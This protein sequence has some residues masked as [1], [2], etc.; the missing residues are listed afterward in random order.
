MP[1]DVLQGGC[2]LVVG[3]AGRDLWLFGW[4][5]GSGDDG[6]LVDSGGDGLAGSLAW[7]GG[8]GLRLLRGVGL[9]MA[10][11]LLTLL[12][13]ACQGRGPGCLLVLPAGGWQAWGSGCLNGGSGPASWVGSGIVAGAGE[14]LGRETARFQGSGGGCW[15]VAPPSPPCTPFGPTT[16]G[17][18]STHCPA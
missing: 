1:G 2:R 14:T 15:V 18:R 12:R 16:E 9:R 10:T 5:G 8:E 13:A 11:P 4:R 6:L 7:R 3:H 17:E